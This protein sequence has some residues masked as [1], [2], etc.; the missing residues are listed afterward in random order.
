MDIEQNELLRYLGW[1][2]QEIDDALQEKLDE[3][4]KRCLEI[5][6]PRSAVM[7]FA[8]DGNFTL[9]G[10]GFALAGIRPGP[11]WRA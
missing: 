5:A 4:A 10:T 1:K 11:A 2:G 3:A 6:S 8:L 9:V 7:R